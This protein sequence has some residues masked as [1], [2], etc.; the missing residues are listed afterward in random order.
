MP[1]S[2]LT[3]RVALVST[4]VLEKLRSSII[5]MTRIGELGI[6]L[7]VISILRSV[8]RWLVRANVVPT[9]PILVTL[10]MERLDSSKTSVLTRGTRRNIPEDDI[11]HSHRRENI[12]SYVA[13]TGWTL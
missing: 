4:D 9:S 10:M 1:S 6:T 12:K 7:A 2:G 5:R 13:L 8:R 11:H 3:R